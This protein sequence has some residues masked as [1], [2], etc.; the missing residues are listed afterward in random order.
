MK[1]LIC[2][3]GLLALI[4][5]MS[6]DESVRFEEAPPMS[7]KALT[8]FP[9][10]LR[11]KYVSDEDD[12]AFLVITKKQAFLR[13]ILPIDEP[14]DSLIANF[15]ED[16]DELVFSDSSAR[17]FT[18]TSTK[19]E[20]M[21]RVK[22]TEGQAIGEFVLE[23]PLFKFTENSTLKVMDGIYY[24]SLMD[25]GETAWTVRRLEIKGDQLILQKME[26]SNGDYE[27]IDFTPTSDHI[28]KSGST[29][30]VMINPQPD[31]LESLFIQFGEVT[32]TFTRTK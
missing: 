30:G 12:S 14:L 28:T 29:D 16:R 1:K 9:K 15:E 20:G 5:I 31:Q 2:F 22:I 23:E 3:V 11:G 4:T 32:R 6:C 24:V 17:G 13:S 10:E 21:A 25:E 18:V 19:E 8:K 26:K 27:L 7:Y